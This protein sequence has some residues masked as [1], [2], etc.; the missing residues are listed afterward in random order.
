MRF[1]ISKRIASLVLALVLVVGLLPVASITTYAAATPTAYDGVPAAPTKITS[2]N[3][4]QFGLTE[5][6][7]SSYNGWYAIRNS[8][9]LYG[10]ASLVNGGDRY[11]SAVLLDDIVINETVSKSGAAYSWV[12]IGYNPNI[13]FMGNFDGNGHSI[14][15][16]YCKYETAPYIGLFG[17]M[18]NAQTTNSTSIKNVVLKNSYICGSNHVGGIL[19]AAIGYGASVSNCVVSQDVTVA[20]SVE[21]AIPCVGGIVGGFGGLSDYLSNK[22][23]TSCTVSNCVNLGTVQSLV[24]DFKE[25]DDYLEYIGSIVGSYGLKDNAF[26]FIV[27]ENCYYIGGRTIDANGNSLDI[28]NN[29]VDFGKG[30]S[31][32]AYCRRSNDGCVL[33]SSAS[34]FHSCVSVTHKEIKATC[35]YPGLSE[36]SCCLICG[37]ITGG[38]RE[39]YPV[40]D[41]SYSD[42]TCKTLSTCVFCGITKGSLAPDNHEGEMTSCAKVDDEKHKGVYSCCGI[43]A[44]APHSISGESTCM[45]TKKCTVCL[46]SIGSIDEDNHVSDEKIY[47]VS[48]SDRTKHDYKWKCCA[49]IIS[50]ESH[51]FD[52]NHDCSVCGYTCEHLKTDNGVCTA[53][54]VSGIGYVYRYWDSVNNTVVSNNAV[55]SGLI[56]IASSTTELTDGWYILDKDI[57]VS[58]RMTVSGTVNLILADGYTLTANKG[59]NVASGNTLNIYGQV[60]ETGKLIASVPSSDENFA[61]VGGGSNQNCGTITINSGTVQ[62]TAL[63]AAAIG[64]GWSGE[65]GSITI[66]GGYVTAINNKSG[67]GIGSGS[68]PDGEAVGTV[69]INGGTVI[70]SNTYSDA[71]FAGAG[72]GG[73]Y[74]GNGYTVII[75]GGN[76]KA[77]S[78]NKAIGAGAEAS[79]PGTLKDSR[80]N[81]VSPHM[82][83]LDSAVADTLVTAVEGINNY[84]LTCVKTLDTNKLY[85]Y[86][87]SGASM[88]AA[89]T[90][91]GQEYICKS[92]WMYYTE[93]DWSQKDGECP[94][95]GEICSHDGA[96]EICPVCGKSFHIHSWAYT[97]ESDTKI[98]ATC[99]AGGCDIPNASGGYVTI[100]APSG[101]TYTGSRIEAVVDNKLTT[102]AAVEVTYSAD[103]INVGTYTASITLDDKTIRAEYSIAAASIVDANVAVGGAFTYDGEAKK[104]TAIT[105]TLNGKTLTKDTDYT[106]SYADNKNA[107]AAKVIVTGAG[108]YQGTAEGSFTIE[109]REIG[110]SWGETEFIPYTGEVIVPQATATGLADGDIC[111]LT[112]S[113]VETTEGAGIIP[114]NW[115]AK[116]TALSNDNYKLPAD[117]KDVTASFGIV[118]GY[119]NYPPVVSAV[120]ETVD[121]KADGKITGV[122]STM[123]YR[124]AGESDYT[125]IT[126]TEITNLADGTYQVRYAAKQYYNA[127]YHTEVV[128]DAGSK[129]TVAVPAIQTGYTIATADTELVWN[130]STTLSFALKDGYSKTSAFAVKVSGNPVELDA[131]GRYVITDAQK[132]IVITVEG[133][134]D[135]TPPAAEIT[136]GTNKWNTFL[137]NI[138][139]GL[140]FKEMQSVTVSAADVNTGS[141][142]NTVYYYLASEELTEDGVSKITAWVE[143]NDTFSIDP[144]KEYIIY[145]KAVDNAGNATYISSTGIVLDAVA[146][147]ISGI[148]NGKTYYTTQ[149]VTITEA[150]VGDV[151]VNGQ[152]VTLYNGAF[153]LAG[154]VDTTYTV[155]VT[156]LAGNSATVTVAMKPISDLSAP[157][158]ALTKDTVNSGN[159]RAVDD[160][161]AAVAAVDTANV[162]DAEKAALK[163][164]FDRAAALEKVIDDTGAERQRIND[165]LGG[166]SD[167][168][169]KSTDQDAI[170]QIVEDIDALI[171]TGN[172]TDDEKKALEDAKTKAKGLLD[173]IR[174]VSEATYTHNTEKVRDVT[175]ENVTPEDKTDLTKAKEDLERAL[176][177]KADN[178]TEA[179]KK[180]VEAEIMRIAEALEVIGNVEAVEALIDKLPDSISKKDEVAIKA[181]DEAYNALSDYEKLLV[182]KDAKKALDDAKA[183]L[184][185]TNKPADTAAPGTGD[186]SNMLLWTALFS[187]SGGAVVTLAIVDRKRRP[188]SKR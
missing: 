156:D 36:Y 176:E 10:F 167:D 183:A 171:E 143:Y 175:A 101:L 49:T 91:G 17:T 82:I 47:S 63:R 114:G 140:F 117:G 50:T 127:S 80:G 163:E 85:F 100:S 21:Y 61:A 109:K 154:N 74:R 118:T 120:A 97:K 178:Y 161:K 147:V 119:Q 98:M 135:I 172:L 26:I 185:E 134:E 141:G 148:G 71:R 104:P 32:D 66:N 48:A 45:D 102:D 155:V 107:G 103:P 184:A 43:T 53:C 72:I 68:N 137:N 20:K 153:T 115:T 129:L 113:V 13:S 122:D 41:H 112:A 70:A 24:A 123:E 126:G 23:S 25:S 86:L 29:L 182:D 12:P 106:V 130:G 27:V 128:V 52:E 111:T 78:A 173:T 139:F 125:A 88:P 81:T 145:G 83:T 1:K 99:T 105:V 108:N 92:E 142:L 16:L 174:D 188:A 164:I 19:G 95:C 55:A 166:Y 160:V 57:T 179:E 149:K 170:E 76:V 138:T 136:L 69:M 2:S 187:I 110:I 62:A 15:G 34:D 168:T 89:I 159:E 56:S 58:Q 54:G 8:K 124:K 144:S 94:R 165:A 121:G 84:G 18:G 40:V 9:E 158:D 28:S 90:A 186:N 67:A 42:A 39:Q 77:T 60:S 31:I 93:H 177:D 59:I 7:Y 116:V 30:G 133:V 152:A 51:S 46:A 5:G 6:N 14:S 181:S 146:P 73:G 162:A 132:N 150:Y 64:G 11:I 180:A 4:Q 169:V 157:I 87:P 75:N 96:G 37:A 131:T 3:Y 79:D 44:T 151:T 33:L 22:F 35:K 65:E 38:T